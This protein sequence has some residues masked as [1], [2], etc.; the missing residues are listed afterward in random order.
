MKN[1]R[2]QL[3]ITNRIHIIRGIKVML[4][5]D[6]TELYGVE[7]RAINQAAKRNKGRFPEDFCFNLDSNDLEDNKSQTVIC[8]SV[9]V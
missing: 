3:D 4:D 8:E 5:R 1:K 9:S 2:T 7:V 6:L